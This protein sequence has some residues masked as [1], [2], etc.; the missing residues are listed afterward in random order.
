MIRSA[1]LGGICAVLC[2]S[3]AFANVPYKGPPTP[4]DRGLSAKD[5]ANTLS[6]K[7]VT[8][9]YSMSWSA[10]GQG[11]ELAV[12]N[13][14]NMAMIDISARKGT[15]EV[16][17]MGNKH[18]SLAGFGDEAYFVPTTSS[19]IPNA[20]ETDVYVRKGGMICIAQLHRTN[21]AGQKMVIPTSDHDI[22]TRLGA[23]C[24]KV[25]AIEK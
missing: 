22:A 3:A 18:M 21:G 16:L 17:L 23:L 8:N 7:I 12:S 19:N 14:T 11:C 15:L 5:V 10:P 24:E 1:I 25:I 9:Q 2:T 13:G 4:C 20:L 6:G